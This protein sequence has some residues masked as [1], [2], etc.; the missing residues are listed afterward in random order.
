MKRLEAKH[1]ALIAG[2]LTS[3]AA[4][5][6]GLKQWGDLFTPAV[7]GGLMGQA[8]TLLSALFV[9]APRN[10]R[11]SHREHPGRRKSDPPPIDE[12]RK[13]LM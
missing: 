8:A 3:T 5:V 4:V 12:M 6:A 13:G 2:F 7:I 9:G 10:P 11:W 1:W